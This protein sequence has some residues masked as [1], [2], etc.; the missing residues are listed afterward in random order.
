MSA[1]P[2]GD[3]AELVRRELA[4]GPGGQAFV[5]TL[6]RGT[7]PKRHLPIVSGETAQ[8]GDKYAL[9]DLPRID[10]LPRLPA[11]RG[12]CCTFAFMLSLQDVADGVRFDPNNPFAIAHDEHGMCVHS[13]E[14][15]CTIYSKR[16]AVCRTYECSKDPRIWIDFEK[17]IA[18]P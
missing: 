15:Q 13:V 1:E 5:D 11:C 2:E 14:C 3:D 6:L 16:P 18:R 10:C 7:D 8:D 17:G 12:R 9:R 4:S